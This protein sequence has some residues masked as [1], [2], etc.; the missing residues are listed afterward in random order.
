M[1]RSFGWTPPHEGGRSEWMKTST[2]FSTM[3][4]SGVLAGTAAAKAQAI[5][6]A[7]TTPAAAPA[8]ETTCDAISARAMA[9][10]DAVSMEP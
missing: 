2:T 4:L 9:V 10:G 7:A 5:T 8:H 1:E 6:T 3:A